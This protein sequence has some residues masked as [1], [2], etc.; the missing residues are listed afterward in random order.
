VNNS[1]SQKNKNENSAFVRYEVFTVMNTQAMVFW[2]LMPYNDLRY[3]H[4]RGPCCLHEVAWFP[5]TLI[6]C[7]I[8][9][10][11]QNS[12]DYNL[13]QWYFIHIFSCSGTR[14][15]CIHVAL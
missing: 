1:L 5:E 6:S 15:M 13:K 9:T 3:Q 14:I 2:V 11:H 8:I 10:Q 12:E 7:H 4:F